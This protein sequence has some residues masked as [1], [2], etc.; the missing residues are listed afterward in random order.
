[1]PIDGM[2]NDLS[3]AP[4][5]PLRPTKATLRAAEQAGGGSKT[6]FQLCMIHIYS[7]FLHNRKPGTWTNAV[8]PKIF[9]FE[10]PPSRAKAV[11][12]TASSNRDENEDEWMMR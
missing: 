1:M 2:V 10:A 3:H 9:L 7:F 5:P 8:Q 6:H 12:W 11:G 4:K